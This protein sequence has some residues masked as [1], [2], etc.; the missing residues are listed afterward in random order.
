MNIIR[1]NLQHVINEFLEWSKV[2]KKGIEQLRTTIREL[3]IAYYQ[4]N[5][6]VVDDT[7]YDTLFALLLEREKTL[8]PED[9]PSDSPSQLIWNQ[10][11]EY[12]EK[13]DHRIPMLSLQNTYNEKDIRE[14]W[15]RCEKILQK[16][17]SSQDKGFW[18]IVE[19]KLDG[20]SIQ[21]TYTYWELS[22]AAT[23]WNGYSGENITEHIKKITTLP[24]RINQWKSI[25]TITLRAEV[26]MPQQAFERLNALHAEWQQFANARNAAAWTLRSLDV[27]L[28]HTRWL[29]C[30]VF[31]VLFWVDDV[32]SHSVM[33]QHLRDMWLPIHEWFET[34]NS[35]DEVVTICK[36]EEVRHE[37]QYGSVACDGLVVKVNW[38]TQRAILWETQHHPRWAIAFKY[39]SMEVVAH[40]R[41]IDRQVGRTGI[42]T[43]VALLDPVAVW[44][45]TV[46]RA[47]LHNVA[48]VYDRKLSPWMNVRIKRS[49]EVIP[50]VI[51]PVDDI[52]DILVQHNHPYPKNCPICTMPTTISEDFKRLVCLN[53]HC[54][55]QLKE[56]LKHFVSRDAANIEWLGARMVEV[57]FDHW[58][59]SKIES[60]YDLNKPQKKHHA[61]TLEWIWTLTWEQIITSIDQSKNQ[62]AERIVYGIGIA[63]VW[64]KIAKL[65]VGQLKDDTI[66]EAFSDDT[67]LYEFIQMSRTFEKLLMIHGIWDELAKNITQRIA[68]EETQLLI[69]SLSAH[70]V[71]TKE[72]LV[73]ESV[74]WDWKGMLSWKTIA[75][76]WT[77]SLWRR[78]LTS[79]IEQQW[80]SVV[81]SLSKS[82]SLLLVWKNPWSKRKKAESLGIPVIHENDSL[83][84]W[85]FSRNLPTVKST[86]KNAEQSLF[87]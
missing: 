53:S 85:I 49:G 40:L 78:E 2:A 43:P 8:L 71:L 9:I 48:F 46:Q 25:E 26:V 41:D 87:A 36:S 62:P 19:P 59:L 32:N 20:S 6:P 65:L 81:S 5:R 15:V 14:W 30:Y 33:M 12:F 51:G 55:A 39:P 77:F 86:E 64:K 74:S 1:E 4:Q 70:N 66:Q 58:L 17:T 82:T 56:K 47:T 50:Y 52:Y 13:S 10:I 76:T 67:S 54:P 34:A 79:L 24:H 16:E 22:H 35:I 3:N 21:I 44:G 69:W 72:K 60:I 80:W 37:T 61:L 42:I 7:T 83:L 75:I 73:S 57:F 29:Q 31:E 11:L 63:W 45:V 68:L 38:Y 84:D 28:V 27:S 23:R 18:Y